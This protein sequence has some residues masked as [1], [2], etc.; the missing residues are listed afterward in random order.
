MD[1]GKTL[2]G[3]PRRVARGV[4]QLDAM[5]GLPLDDLLKNKNVIAFLA[6]LRKGEVGT[7]EPS[8][9][10]IV[11]GGC[12]FDGDAYPFKSASL[13]DARKLCSRALSTASGGY[14]FT[15]ETWLDVSRETGIRGFGQADQ[16]RLAVAHLEGLGVLGLIL[17]GL[18]VAAMRP[19]V[20]KEPKKSKYQSLPGSDH[21]YWPSVDAALAFYRAQGGAHG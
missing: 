15:F 3:R 13:A 8:G 16:D 11:S 1:Y 12:R 18:P 9:Y 21:P 19:L 4:M 2:N 7:V 20:S 17:M 5:R 10:K 14:Q 6:L